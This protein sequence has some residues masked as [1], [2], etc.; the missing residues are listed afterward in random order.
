MTKQIQQ[1]MQELA[2]EIARHDELYHAKD[3]PEISDAEYDLLRRRYEKLAKDYPQYAV[4]GTL[5][6]VGAAPVAG[7]RK[8]AH[9]V[10]MLS[11]GN[12]FDDEDVMDFVQRMRRFLN[13]PDDAQIPSVAEPKLD[14]LSLSLRYERGEFIYA[15]T[16]GDGAI[17]EDVTANARTIKDI[18]Q[19]LSGHPPDVL[20]VR[21]EIFMHRDD[22]QRLN[23]VQT[24][25]GRPAFANPRNAAAGSMRQL[26]PMITATRP[27]RFAA[28]TWG[29]VSAPLAPTL[30]EARAKLQSFGFQLNA[31]VALCETEKD[32]L[33][34]YQKFLAARADLPFDIDGVVYKVND[35]VLQNQ[36][37]FVARAPRWAIAHKF[38]AEQALTRLNA[39][40]IQVG[41]TGALTPVAELEPINVGGVM[42][43]RATLHNEDEIE[44]K[45]AR[46]GDMVWVQRA[47]D[48]IPQILGFKDD[49]HHAV[50]AK[51]VFPDHCPVCGAAAVRPEG[52]AVRRC[53]NGLACPAQALEHLR[54]FVSRGAAD[55]AGLGER[56]LA[57]FYELGWVRTPVDIFQI[58]KHQD[59]LLQ[60]EGWKEK[61]VS[62]LLL[63]IERARQMPMA[64]FIYA[65]GIRQIGDTTA[66][67]LARHFSS[68]ESFYAA[69]QSDEAEA[70]LIAMDG[71]GASM[72]K[73]LLAFFTEPHNQKVLRALTQEIQIQPEG[74]SQTSGVLSGKTVVFTGTLPTL[75]RDAAK[76]MAERA[77]AKVASSV[78]AKTDF[79]V[80]GED[81]GSKLKKAAELGVKVLSEEGFTE[82]L[83]Q[84]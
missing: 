51:F 25:A 8:I 40:T 34:F 70:E 79:V 47:G 50:R 1:T 19:K 6:K 81:A 37:G 42:V 39:I 78:S 48:V 73:D 23:D 60:R 31:P 46:A 24:E 15:V 13:L 63:A 84:G 68:W 57:E 28:Y 76:A 56:T 2:A 32:L 30:W 55:I 36:L 43:S 74:P 62:N 65:L 7:F 38:P 77:G 20:E 29:E 75:S 82:I 12:A 67:L 69:M 61:S 27:L 35:L 52:E 59:E 26:D 5:H 45:D 22:F 11:L 4:A 3:A 80:A 66:K 17:G 54:H 71:V 14:G 83:N 44:R 33:E 9:V 64:R 72:A 53:T 58:E 49:G 10:P 41:R 18:P 21:G 16:R